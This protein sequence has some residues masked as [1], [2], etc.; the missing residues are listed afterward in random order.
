MHR[1]IHTELRELLFM[2]NISK[3]HSSS[4]FF[5]IE[6]VKGLISISAELNTHF[7]TIQ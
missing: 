1:M 4:I 2:N 5:P 3:Q 7:I 6:L